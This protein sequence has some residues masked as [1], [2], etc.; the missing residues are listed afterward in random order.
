MAS[1]G[2]QLQKTIRNLEKIRDSQNQPSD[3]VLTA[4]DTLYGQQID[5]IDAAI[6]KSTDEYKKATKAM[7]K[8]AQKTKKAI[9]DLAKLEKSIEKVAKAIGLVVELLAYAT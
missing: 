5:L 4:L 2:K 8:A 3:D 9:D 6:K 1:L 7:K